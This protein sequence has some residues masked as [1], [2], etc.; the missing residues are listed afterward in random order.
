MWWAR[1]ASP[2]LSEIRHFGL[3][4]RTHQDDP[5]ARS[6]AWRS[7]ASG[8]CREE[9]SSVTLRELA[10]SGGNHSARND[11]LADLTIGGVASSLHGR[12]VFGR[13]VR[14]LA[15]H[16][17]ALIPTGA[18]TVLDVGCGD[19]T[20][21]RGMTT[22]RPELRP[23]GLEV[24]ARPSTAIPVTEFDGR[25]I[26]FGDRSH[27]VVMLID[28]LH[29]AEDATMLVTE[30]A[31]VARR[32]VIIKDHLADPWLGRLRLRAMDWVGNIGHGVDLR[33]AYWT[34]GQWNS[35][36]ARARLHEEERRERLGL[37]PT[38]TRWLFETGLHFMSRLVPLADDR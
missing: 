7:K 13:R 25:T 24:R 34:R 19:G 10:R 6:H 12:L 30:A 28:V 22:L 31:R 27:D 36:F 37:Y 26:P 29:H 9:H 33:N 3:G 8:R 35:A 21:A 5:A 23:S 15:S 11:R 1:R 38:G 18:T 4:E 17:A 2:R 32:A 20:L 16:V 14:V